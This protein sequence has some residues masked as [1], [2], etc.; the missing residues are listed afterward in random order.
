MIVPTVE[1]LKERL[2]MK[3]SATKT[4]STML[5]SKKYVIELG[6]LITVYHG[7]C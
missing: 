3:V 4:G 5:S 1:N 2:N 6:K 7:E